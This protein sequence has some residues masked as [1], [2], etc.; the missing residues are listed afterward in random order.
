MDIK[1]V[2]I[3]L[4][5]LLFMAIY[6]DDTELIKYA[7]GTDP[8]NLITD[9]TPK[10]DIQLRLGGSAYNPLWLAALSF[11]IKA[12][13]ECIDAIDFSYGDCVNYLS[14]F[15]MDTVHFKATHSMMTYGM[16]G[17]V[18][19][20]LGDDQ[21]LLHVLLGDYEEVN[22]YN[23]DGGIWTADDT[24]ND[25]DGVPGGG[26]QLAAGLGWFFL[27]GLESLYGIRP[28][29]AWESIHPKPKEDTI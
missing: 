23:P 6:Y 21:D 12:F 20:K 26:D 8:H 29:T 3:P 2:K 1:D 18:A 5:D 14:D 7:I 10:L 13:K 25:A 22:W 16:L 4:A 11:N 9:V 15:F 17:Y 19:K 24:I 28:D 27:D